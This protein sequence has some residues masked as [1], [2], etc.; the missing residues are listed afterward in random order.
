MLTCLPQS[1]CSWNFRILGASAGPGSV[2]F[3]FF[4]EQGGITLGGAEFAVRKH[5][6]LSGHWTLEQEGRCIT[7]ARKP[8]ALLRSFDL[9]ADGVHLRLC[10]SSPFTR[11]YEILSDGRPLG[12]IRPAH[13]FTRRAFIDC[14]SEVPEIVQ[15]FSFWLAVLMWRR[16]AQDNA[17]A[18][19]H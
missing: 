11:S 12:T 7:D 3:N 8:N 4:T 19:T 9:V 13:P 17:A 6:P 14:A 15:L 16:Q 2:A 5:G 1:P 10:A 18:S